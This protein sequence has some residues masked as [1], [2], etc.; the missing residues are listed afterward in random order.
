MLRRLRPVNGPIVESLESRQLLAAQ[1]PFYGMPFKVPISIQAEQYDSGGA[2]VSFNDSERTNLG[3]ASYRAGGVDFNADPNTPGNYYV[4]HTKSGEWLEYTVQAD[5]TG[6]YDMKIRL[7]CGGAGGRFHILI[8]G[9]DQGTTAVKNTGGWDSF[10]TVARNDMLLTGGQHVVRLEFSKANV[11]GSDI[12]DLDWIRFTRDTESSPS[13]LNAAYDWS[14][15]SDGPFARY[16]GDGAIVNGKLYIFGGYINTQI[17]ATTRSDMYDPSTGKWTRI[18]DMPEPL[19]HTGVAVHGTTIWLVGGFLGDH[20]GPGT[21]HVW[22]YNTLSNTCSRGPALP[23]ARGAGA[24]AMDGDVLHFFGGLTHASSSANPVKSDMADHWTLD[25]AN[26]G[27]WKTAAP[28]INPR[29]HLAGAS[30]NGKIYAIGGQHLWDENN[31]VS[32]VDVYSPKTSRWT[33]VASM[34]EGRSHIS[35]STLVV[36]GRIIVIGGAT[37]GFDSLASVIDYD[38]ATDKWGKL[39]SL[40][41]PLATTVAGYFNDEFVVAT[42]SQFDLVATADVFIGWPA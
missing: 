22:R 5:T 2:G 39:S 32:E 19:T 7:S 40:P 21:T 4:S 42:G 24:A 36:D 31:P 20:P 29:N 6:V 38:P 12:A 11:T 3:D 23:E 18:A 14:Q 35:S 9:V 37:N 33:K 25:L 10:S 27:G 41:T 26:G 15:K 8:D 28:M 16:E 30:L 1:T 13:S 17:Q 34:P